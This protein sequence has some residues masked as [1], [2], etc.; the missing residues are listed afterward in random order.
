M[1]TTYIVWGSD[2]TVQDNKDDAVMSY[3]FDTEAELDAFLKGV[4]E[5][6]GWTEYNNFDT[7]EEA[8]EYVKEVS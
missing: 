5:S 3:S 4:E 1:F 2:M 7:E 6:S 8:L